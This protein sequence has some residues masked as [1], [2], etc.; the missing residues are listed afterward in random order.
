MFLFLCFVSSSAHTMNWIGKQTKRRYMRTRSGAGWKKKTEKTEKIAAEKNNRH[1]SILP[2]HK[3]VFYFNSC[4]SFS[5]SFIS[6]C[7]SSSSYFVFFSCYFLC[8]VSVCCHLPFFLF[9]FSIRNLR[10]KT[11]AD[12]DV[13]VCVS[14][15]QEKG[16][17]EKKKREY[18][19]NNTNWENSI[20]PN[21]RNARVCD[22]YGVCVFV[23]DCM[24]I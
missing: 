1:N 20:S 6:F 13:C 5:C 16:F 8:C 19:C 2:P 4:F 17:A 18:K 14:N 24:R 11:D 7:T 10:A 12:C 9:S 23:C 21:I 3:T 15:A 22:V